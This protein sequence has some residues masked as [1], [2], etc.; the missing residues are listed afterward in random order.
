MY[1]TDKAAPGYGYASSIAFVQ[2]TF[3]YQGQS[4]SRQQVY[5]GIP[6][7]GSIREWQT[8][9]LRYARSLSLVMWST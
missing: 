2:R 1:P 4:S 3:P 5:A 8:W 9:T 7:I 6:S